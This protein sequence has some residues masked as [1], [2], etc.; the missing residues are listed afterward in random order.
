[1]KNAFVLELLINE[2]K[3]LTFIELK[4]YKQVLLK[5]DILIN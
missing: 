2:N 3:Q 5:R 1:M 4:T